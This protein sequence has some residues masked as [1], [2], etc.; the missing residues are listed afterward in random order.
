MRSS[1]VTKFERIDKEGISCLAA[2]EA[3]Y[4]FNVVLMSQLLDVTPPPPPVPTTHTHS[5]LPSHLPRGQRNRSVV[6]PLSPGG[7]KQRL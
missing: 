2:Y 7:R 5:Q 6:I 1:Y 4:R 3:F